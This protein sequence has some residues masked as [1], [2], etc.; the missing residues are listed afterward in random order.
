MKSRNSSQRNETFLVTSV[1][2]GKKFVFH[3][4]AVLYKDY[5]TAIIHVKQISLSQVT[6]IINESRA[7]TS[8]EDVWRKCVRRR[9]TSARHPHKTS[10]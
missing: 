5:V 2:P 4:A 3:S 1:R 7:A 8:S 6:L 10:K 9:Q